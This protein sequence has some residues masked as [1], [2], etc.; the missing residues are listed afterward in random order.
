MTKKI[1]CFVL[2]LILSM[3]L[4]LVA[5]AEN[6][7]DHSPVTTQPVAGNVSD[8]APVTA[9]PAAGNVSDTAP[10]TAAQPSAYELYLAAEKKM[11]GK[12]FGMQGVV[13]VAVTVAGQDIAETEAD[14]TAKIRENSKGELEM[15]I[16][17]TAEVAGE[18][19][20]IEQY[21]KDGYLYMNAAGEKTKT[22]MP[23]LEAK[24]GI[25]HE[26]EIPKEFFDDATVEDVDGGKLIRFS[27]SG[28]YM[29]QL[30]KDSVDAAMLKEL[31]DISFDRA[32]M[33]IKIGEDGMMK[34]YQMTYRMS[35]EVEGTAM[36]LRTTTAANIVSVGQVYSISFPWDLASYQTI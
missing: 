4:S 21:F 11:E 6:V 5:A 22:V 23:A 17:T 8:R 36:S 25:V 29:E 24:R 28:E 9:Q 16:L 19:I 13:K 30:I 31:G 1:I 34:A 3:S 10:V 35:A 32:T 27:L 14:F 2:V 26:T 7:T 15:S 12:S 33:W 18:Q 20:R